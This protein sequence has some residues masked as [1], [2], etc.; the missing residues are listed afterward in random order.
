MDEI[1]L[2]IFQSKMDLISEEMGM[3][4]GRTAQST[5]FAESHDY[6]C[7]LSGPD[8]HVVSYAD[9]IPM[10]TGSVGFGVQRCIEYWAGEIEEGDVYL[11][12]DP[13]FCMSIHL[14]DWTVVVPIHA[15]DGS[16]MGFSGVRAHMIDVGGGCM[17]GYNSDAREIYQE[18][19]RLPPLR[20]YDKGNPRKDI[21]DLLR[22]NTRL[23]EIVVGDLEAMVGACRIGKRRLRALED[24]FT[25]DDLKS[26]FAALLDYGERLMRH[27]IAAV[28][29]GTYTGTEIMNNN[30]LERVD[31][32]IQVA[33]TIEG[34]AVT[35]DFAG[36]SEQGP[37]F[38]NS[39]YAATCAATYLALRT[40][41]NPIA[42]MNDGAYRMVRVLAPKG[43]VVNPNPPA[44]CA[45][46]GPHPASEII[47]AC[48]RALSKVSSVLAQQVSAGWGAQVAPVTTSLDSQGKG[49][50]M[51]HFGAM[52]GAGATSQRDGLD[53][54]GMLSAMGNLRVPSVEVYEQAYPVHFLAHE[55]RTDG[56]GAGLF[57]GGTGVHYE[58]E[59]D[60]PATWSFRCEG[61][62]TPTGFGLE[63]GGYGKE[64][65]LE[66][67]DLDSGENI[68]ATQYGVRSLP[69]VELRIYAPGGGGWGSP[70]SRDPQLVLDDV[71]DGL[72]SVKAARED[73]GV[74]IQPQEMEI[75][76]AATSELRRGRSSQTDC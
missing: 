42:P 38:K 2:S 59:V 23:P 69:P 20:L 54:V 51:Y 67:R 47:H 8:G 13:Y 46:Y 37:G 45:M 18:G 60:R 29:D 33:I 34:S 70:Y 10:H 32:T 74:V 16:L 21:W 35:V 73:Y 12:N 40:V 61:L 24:K 27:H 53:Q 41:L 72:V 36:T 43:S 4:L 7:F 22:L 1:E 71:I 52:G 50:A 5:I 75:D 6:S 76:Q 25:S 15:T 39:P 66:M 11:F 64:G 55:F 65:V 31:V 3:V 63:G 68:P 49:Y 44:A 28:P 9:G 58:L 62:Y 17:G 14:P 56:G 30:A 19:I 48:W 57:R 26:G